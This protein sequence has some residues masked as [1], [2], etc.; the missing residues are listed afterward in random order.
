MKQKFQLTLTLI[1]ILFSFTGILILNSQLKSNVSNDLYNQTILY[2]RSIGE[3]IISILNKSGFTKDNSD[4]DSILQQICD[5]SKL[6]NSGFICAIDSSG[7]MT[8]GPGLKPGMTMEF[9]PVIYSKGNKIKRSPAGLQRDETFEG[10]AEFIDEGRQDILVSLPVHE[11]LRLFIHQNNA[12]INKQ[13]AKSYDFVIKTGIAFCLLLAVLV[14]FSTGFIISKYQNNNSELEKEINLYLQKIE[15]TKADLSSKNS[16]IENLQKDF[17]NQQSKLRTLNN[18][19]NDSIRYA[20]QM[21][22]AALSMGKIGQLIIAEY[23]ILFSPKNISSGDFYWYRDFEEFLILAAFDCNRKGIQG[24]LMS[25]V[26]INF[27]NEVKVDDKLKD[28]GLILNQLWKNL[29]D[30]LNKDYASEIKVSGMDI[31]LCII[32]KK[33]YSL[34]FASMNHSLLCMREGIIHELK[35]DNSSGKSEE[36]MHENFT[37][38]SLKLRKKDSLYLFTDGFSDQFGGSNRKKF[39]VSNFKRLLL[40]IEGLQ[41]KMQKDLLKDTFDSWQ[42]NNIQVDDVLVIGLLV[43]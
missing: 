10:I 12:Q 40:E 36:A 4:S 9:M 1:I 14:Y 6:P 7:H 29:M 21:H 18:E 13:S 28:A 38:Q 15:L 17:R 19:V 31:S 37:N 30:K 11:N 32:N 2:N 43:N 5:E 27:L 26:G 22:H 33:E 24:A 41:M 23:F 34:Q 42:G 20:R 25:L 35:G 39:M 16:M 8:A 3:Q